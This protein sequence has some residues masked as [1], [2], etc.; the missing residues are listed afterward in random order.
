MVTKW[1]WLL[2]ASQ[3]REPKKKSLLRI[4]QEGSEAGSLFAIEGRILLKKETAG[5]N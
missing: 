5:N 1:P 2:T 4:R 3:S